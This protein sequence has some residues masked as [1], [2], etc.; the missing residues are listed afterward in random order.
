M[1]D[2]FDSPATVACMRG[3]DGRW[4]GFSTRNDMVGHAFTKQVDLEAPSP[5]QFYVILNGT[6]VELTPRNE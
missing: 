6:A 2:E 4:L 3:G 1:P 5:D